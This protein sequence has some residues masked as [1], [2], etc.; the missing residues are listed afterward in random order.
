M[1]ERFWSLV[2]QKLAGE[3]TP[4]ELKELEELL[5]LHP[6]W[7]LRM[8]AFSNLWQT[9]PS[10]TINKADAFNRHMQRLSTHQAPPPMQYEPTTTKNNPRPRRI[11][12]TT[13]ATAAAC[14][15]TALFF[16]Y[17]YK[18]EPTTGPNTITTRPGSRSK[19][20]LPDGSLVWLN[21]DSKLSYALS[22]TGY[23]EV[24]LTG[25]AYFDVAKDKNHPFLIHTPTMDIKVLGTVFNVRSYGND[26][27]TEA[28]LFQG[29]IEV[30]L[31]GNP[32]KK[33]VL[34]PSE[35]LLVHN[36]EMA[37][38]GIKTD[39]KKDEDADQPIMTLGKVRYRQEDSSYLEALWIKN[40][41]VFDN[42]TLEELALRLE[43]WYAVKV[44]I[45]DEKL[46]S[47]R[48]SGRFEL[49]NLQQVMEAIRLSG[50][51]RYSIEK[52]EVI[53]MPQ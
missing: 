24:N 7:G 6:E 22:P 27:N 9:R 23:R 20:Q 34:Q 43:R 3:A 28:D 46:K 1:E 44:T 48:F 52:K 25:E 5:R 49:E 42:L 35:K 39:P 38:T 36:N 37:V 45:T 16:L 30:A 4:D 33:I 21:A 47:Q 2:S 17:Q 26:R 50:D 10:G 29:S 18:K 15:L 32:D 40:Q 13:L 19:V 31:H 53:I 12:W 51:L 8:Q 11:L 14:L 41:L